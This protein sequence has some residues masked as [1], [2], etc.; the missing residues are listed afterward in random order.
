MALALLATSGLVG[1]GSSSTIL[2]QITLPGL[3]WG[4]EEVAVLAA[5][6]LAGRKRQRDPEPDHAALLQGR[7]RKWKCSSSCACRFRFGVGVGGWKRG[8]RHGWG[9]APSI[10]RCPI[11][12][13]AAWEEISFG[14]TGE[15]AVAQ[16]RANCRHPILSKAEG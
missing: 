5:L 16:L 13:K 12:S 1:R 6:G 4:G 9:Q 8:G 11:P 14:G 3:G 15:E 10:S 2:S 7:K